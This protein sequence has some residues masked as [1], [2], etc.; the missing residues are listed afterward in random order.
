[1]H[2]QINFVDNNATMQSLFRATSPQSQKVLP[3]FGANL[4]LGNNSNTSGSTCDYYFTLYGSMETHSLRPAVFS[5]CVFLLFLIM[6]VTFVVYHGAVQRRIRQAVVEAERS[7]AL[8]TSLFPTSVH[9][10]LFGTQGDSDEEDDESHTRRSVRG[11]KLS[12]LRKSAEQKADLSN[13]LF[14]DSES[15]EMQDDDIMYKTKPIADLFPS[16]TIL[17]SDISG[18]T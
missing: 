18:F 10:R 16:V 13:N 3:I 6:S 14:D 15:E 5:T 11:K 2:L 7:N 4:G 1:M 8:V 17:F 12:K 9:D